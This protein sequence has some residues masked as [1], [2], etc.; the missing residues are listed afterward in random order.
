MNFLFYFPLGKGALIVLTADG[1]LIV[2]EDLEV[3][4]KGT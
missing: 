2:L 4:K 3:L 1:E